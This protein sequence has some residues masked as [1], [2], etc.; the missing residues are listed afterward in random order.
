[1]STKRPGV[2]F[3][4]LL[5]VL[6]A[7]V[8]PSG[9]ALAQEPEGPMRTAVISDGANPG[10]TLTITLE[11]VPA[12]QPGTALEGWLVTDDW[13]GLVSTGT[14]SIDGEGNVS[15]TY[16]SPTGDNL[17]AGFNKFVVTIEPVPDPSA[18]PSGNYAF[19]AR[20]K[21]SAMDHIR[22]LLISW[23]PGSDSGVIHNLSAQL[24]LAIE[25]NRMASS[26][27]TLEDMQMYAQRVINIIEGSDGANFDASAG[28]PG[29]GVGV[30]THISDLENA[31]FA[32]EEDPD[33][34]VLAQHAALVAASAAN[35]EARVTDA[36]DAAVS[37][38]GRSSVLD[39]RLD[40]I[41]V[42][43]LLSSALNG[44]DANSDGMIE[45]GGAEGGTSQAYVDAQRMATYQLM[46]GE[47][48]PLGPEL[49]IGLSRTGGEAAGAATLIALAAAAVA[50]VGAGALV[51]RRRRARSDR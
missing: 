28:N 23:P 7:M 16:V 50:A 42:A 21:L 29:D 48:P 39:A 47:L 26:A 3:A 34:M 12:Q 40:L 30:M 14:M 22:Y 6:L 27:G 43:G 33:N 8:I 37:S 13:E 41:P 38:L 35:I 20:V 15:H 49:G 9:L 24:S 31:M 18:D 2:R 10:D 44:L 4:A 45:S 5:V 36:R 17:I 51:L 11:A 19:G 32:S 46:E 25:S 1:M